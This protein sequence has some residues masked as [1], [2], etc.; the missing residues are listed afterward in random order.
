VTCSSSKEFFLLYFCVTECVQTRAE[1]KFPRLFVC[2]KNNNRRMS[3]CI[4]VT[5]TGM[6]IKQIKCI[7][8]ITFISGIL[9]LHKIDGKIRIML[10]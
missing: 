1:I 7:L 2:K 3:R 6:H 10:R 9:K 4:S 8:G 5:M